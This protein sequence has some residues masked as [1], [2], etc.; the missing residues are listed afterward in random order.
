MRSSGLWVKCK[1]P[2]RTGHKPRLA[3][4]PHPHL[5]P[6]GEASACWIALARQAW[7]AAVYWVDA[8]GVE[9]G[10]RATGTEDRAGLHAGHT[11]LLAGGCGYVT[12]TGTV[13]ASRIEGSSGER[14]DFVPQEDQGDQNAGE[15]LAQFVA[16]EPVVEQARQGRGQ[17]YLPEVWMPDRRG[18]CWGSRSK[19]GA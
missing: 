9:A 17:G 10:D 2:L 6:G 19:S 4:S 14:G 5:P 3:S 13:R 7:P 12:V 8:V 18:A 1:A 15:G 16:L 11:F